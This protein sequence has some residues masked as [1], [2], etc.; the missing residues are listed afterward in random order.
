MIALDRQ[1]QKFFPLVGRRFVDIESDR[2]VYLGLWGYYGSESIDITLLRSR[3]DSVMEKANENEK[4]VVFKLI[5]DSACSECGEELGRGRLL[6]VEKT[7]PLCLECAGLSHLLFLPGGNAK[8]TRRAKRYS[9]ISAVVVKFSRAR[10][11]YERQGLL[12][13][14][15]ALDRAEAECLADADAQDVRR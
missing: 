15:A 7:R 4:I 1:I 13:S 2:N 3:R 6:R 9:D 11:R 14:E 5:T 8:L 12:V 10:K